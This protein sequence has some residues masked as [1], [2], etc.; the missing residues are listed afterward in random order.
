M[1]EDRREKREKKE[2]KEKRERN[3]KKDKWERRNLDREKKRYPQKTEKERERERELSLLIIPDWNLI[4]LAGLRI[5]WLHPLRGR[6]RVRPLFK[7]SSVLNMTLYCIWRW[8]FSF[9]PFESVICLFTTTTPRSQFK[10]SIEQILALNNP[11][12]VDMMNE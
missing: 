4:L 6:G 2:R 7:K 1:T 8:H 12:R 3:E 5:H 11:F 9:E 10:K